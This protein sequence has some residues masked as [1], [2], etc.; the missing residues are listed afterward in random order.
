MYIYILFDTMHL[1]FI[2]YMRPYLI[3]SNLSAFKRPMFFVP[4]SACQHRCQDPRWP[5]RAEFP[6][7][8]GSEMIRY[9]I[10]VFIVGTLF[11]IN[12][13]R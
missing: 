3:L 6:R 4:L 1:S 8:H 11:P 9:C 5:V 2:V 7:Q 10:Y 12:M 13:S